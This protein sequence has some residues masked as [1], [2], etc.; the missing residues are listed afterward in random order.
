MSIPD[1]SQAPLALLTMDGHC[2]LVAA[3]QVLRHFGLR[4][5]A[6][7]IPPACGYTKRYGVFTIGLAAGL[8]ELGLDVAFHSELDLEVR[9]TERRCYA[10][11]RARGIPI[12]GALSL[13]QVLQTRSQRAVPIVFYETADGQGHFSPLIGARNGRLVLPLDENRTVRREDFLLRWTAPGVL[14]Q[15]IIVKRR[16][17]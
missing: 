14:R 13:E 7:R 12:E 5:P 2:G 6:S 17:A 4:V 1:W 8:T 10:R 16:S 11:A 15:A 9:A 3:W